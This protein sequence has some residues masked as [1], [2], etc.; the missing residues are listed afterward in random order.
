[1]QQSMKGTFQQLE[2]TLDAKEDEVSE[3]KKQVGVLSED[4]SKLRAE[5]EESHLAKEDLVA[6]ASI[7]VKAV[8]RE[9][10]Q[11]NGEMGRLE[12]ELEGPWLFDEAKGT[13]F[14]AL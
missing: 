14:E 1:M 13:E 4:V 7:Q 3:L 5:L 12:E 10:D 2:I 11:L 6:N 9:N 8:R